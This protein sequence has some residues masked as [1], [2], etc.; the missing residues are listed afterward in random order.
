LN[1]SDWVESG[2]PDAAVSRGAPLPSVDT[3][4]S[5]QVVSGK[6][7]A[8]VANAGSRHA[9]SNA[10]IETDRRIVKTPG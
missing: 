6:A 2:A 8:G 10:A 5:V 4:P 7:A 3:S 1:G 9:A